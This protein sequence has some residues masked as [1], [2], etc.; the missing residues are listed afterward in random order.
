MERLGSAL[1]KE[2]RQQEDALKQRLQAKIERR[3]SRQSSSVGRRKVSATLGAAATEE[4]RRQLELETNQALESQRQ[5]SEMERL[6]AV[7]KQGMELV[8]RLV[9]TGRFGEDELGGALRV[10]FPCKPTSELDAM[11]DQI[12]QNAALRK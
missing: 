1:A 2:R 10:L 11:L 4:A 3:I 8:A 12:Y 9:Q 5:K 6:A 7:E